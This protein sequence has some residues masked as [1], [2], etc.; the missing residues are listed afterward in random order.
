[1]ELLKKYTMATM[2]KCMSCGGSSMKMKKG[3]IK[4]KSLK[5]AQ[6]G[7]S[8][9][10]VKKDPNT[11]KQKPTMGVPKKYAK[12]GSS[13][14]VGM[15]QYTNNPRSYSGASLKHGGRVKGSL[16]KYQD[17]GEVKPAAREDIRAARTAASQTPRMTPSAP[18][19]A[20]R[21][22]AQS[23]I[24]KN[25]GTARRSQGMYGNTTPG[26]MSNPDPYGPFGTAGPAN[27]A[28]Q[29]LRNDFNS[30]EPRVIEQKPRNTTGMKRGGTV[31]KK[32][33]RADDGIIV[34]PKYPK[35]KTGKPKMSNDNPGPASKVG[36]AGK[37][38][39][40][41]FGISVKVQRSPRAGKVT[42]V[43]RGYAAVGKREP[44][45]IIKKK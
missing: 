41:K 34:K 39:M 6:Y 24:D 31:G 12:G 16:K 33:K 42:G 21:V 2:K 13:E 8:T 10:P 40:A 1:V 29:E 43:N 23:M 32:L 15:P 27:Q 28:S 17:L 7:L 14:I 38:L 5:K 18:A 19:N 4:K 20:A 9:D 36:K 30:L 26:K 35:T 11:N 3:G 44:G 25:D 45:R 22:R 37:T